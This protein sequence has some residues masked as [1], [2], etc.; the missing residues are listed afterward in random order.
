MTVQVRAAGRRIQVSV[1]DQGPGIP[2]HARE[3]VFER[4]WSGSDC[5]G[6]SGLGLAIG[7]TIAR[8]HGG[9][10][11]LGESRSGCCELV[12]ELPAASIDGVLSMA[13]PDAA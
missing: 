2:L 1:A 10:L 3:P 13:P 6:H 9:E 8:R 4:F 5:G 11:R 12:V 7:R